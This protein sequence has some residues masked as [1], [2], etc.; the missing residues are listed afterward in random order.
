VTNANPAATASNEVNTVQ[1]CYIAGLNP[2]D[3]DAAFLI[4]DFSPQSSVL[5]WNATSGRVYTVYWT[6][7]LLSGFQPLETNVAWT[8]VPFTDTNHPGEEKGFYKIEVE[9]E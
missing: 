9:L 5:G 4:S 6:S 1:D 8:A 2:T 3:P 7:N